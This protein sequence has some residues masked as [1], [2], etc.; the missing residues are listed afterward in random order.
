MKESR[1]GRRPSGTSSVDTEQEVLTIEEAMTDLTEEELRE[2]LQGDLLD[3]PVDPRFKERL[4]RRLWK[5]VQDQ[6]RLRHE[7]ERD[8][9]G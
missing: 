2:F 5:L 7:R 9:D 6:A 1:D 3:V 4:K 8:P